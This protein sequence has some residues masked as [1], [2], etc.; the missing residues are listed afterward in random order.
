MAE[1]PGGELTGDAFAEMFGGEEGVTGWKKR[2]CSEAPKRQACEE[3]FGQ[4]CR[5]PLSIRWPPASLAALTC[6]PSHSRL[7]PL[8]LSVPRAAWPY[9]ALAGGFCSSHERP[10][11]PLL[12]LKLC[13]CPAPPPPPLWHWLHFSVTLTAICCLTCLYD[14]WGFICAQAPLIFLEWKSGEGGPGP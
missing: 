9:P 4:G 2:F 14:V 1:C 12:P 13:P 11:L 5:R 7:L 3:R 8:L 6:C 10:F